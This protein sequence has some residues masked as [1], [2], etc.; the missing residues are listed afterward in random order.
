MTTTSFDEIVLL[1]LLAQLTYFT[2]GH[3]ATLLSLQWK[4]AF[5]FSSKLSYSLSP[6]LVM[7]NMLGPTVLIASAA[8]LLAIWNRAPLQQQQQQVQDQDREEEQSSAGA[9]ALLDST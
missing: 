5:T 3:Q 8:P 2:T 1:V 6:S 7:L 4:S 9:V